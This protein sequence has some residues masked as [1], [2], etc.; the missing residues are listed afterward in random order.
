MKKILI[1]LLAVGMLVGC[2]TPASSTKTSSTSVTQKETK[3]SITSDVELVTLAPIADDDYTDTLLKN[4][5][6]DFSKLHLQKSADDYFLRDLTLFVNNKG[7]ILS[8]SASGNSVKN[9]GKI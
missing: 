9:A 3:L 2:S 7:E 1:S 8:C 5:T 6:V 4:N